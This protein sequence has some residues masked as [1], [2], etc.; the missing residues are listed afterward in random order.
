ML[1]F[2]RYGFAA[3]MLAVS[4]LAFGPLSSPAFAAADGEARSKAGWPKPTRSVKPNEK[5]CKYKFSD[6]EKTVWICDKAVPCCEWEAIGNYVK[7]GTTFSGC[8]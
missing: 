6:G 4:A 8:L 3:L 1:R 7:C 2:A 5:L